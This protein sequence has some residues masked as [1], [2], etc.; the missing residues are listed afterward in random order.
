MKLLQL[1][2][3]KVQLNLPLPWNVRNEPGELLP[4]TSAL[5]GGSDT[6]RPRHAVSR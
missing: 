2:A 3:A 1:C 6:G 5:F 4:S